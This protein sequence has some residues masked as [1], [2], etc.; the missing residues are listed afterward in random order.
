[1]LSMPRSFT[2]SIDFFFLLN[3]ATFSSAARVYPSFLSTICKTSPPPPAPSLALLRPPCKGAGFL[4]RAPPQGHGGHLRVEL[5]RRASS[6]IASRPIARRLH[7][8]ARLANS[9]PTQCH[10]LTRCCP[11]PYGTSP[12]FPWHCGLMSGCL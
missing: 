3:L 5:E 9:R 1:M 11:G 10:S 4:P 7:L 12:S 2:S 6:P 8:L